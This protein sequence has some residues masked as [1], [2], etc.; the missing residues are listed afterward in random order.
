MEI[1]FIRHGD[2]DYEIDG[3]TEDG[4]KQA[5]ALADYLKNKSFDGVYSSPLGRAHLTA[6]TCFKEDNIIVLDWLKEFTHEI[7]LSDGTKQGNWDFMPSYICKRNELYD[8]KY[9]NA[10]EMKSGDIAKYYS[11][12]VNGFDKLLSEYGYVR[13]G[14]YYCAINSNKKRIVLFCHFGVMSVIMSHIMNLPHVIIAQH[15]CASPSSI[16]TFVTEEREKGIAQFRCLSYG[17]TPHLDIK[18]I[19]PGFAARFCETFDSN[20]RH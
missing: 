7:T 3:L 13:T 10:S 9:L 4:K 19:E 11:E 1:I 16:T 18:G 14:R 6:K 5:K 2:P 20:D 17:A 15:F 8:M 12:V